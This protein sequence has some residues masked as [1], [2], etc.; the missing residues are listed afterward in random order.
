MTMGVISRLSGVMSSL[1]EGQ[2][3]G[4]YRIVRLLGQGGMGAVYEARQEPLD[5]RVALKTLHADYAK[6][7]DALARF[8]NE[9]KALSKLE[10]PSIVQVS[11]FRNAADGTAYLV[12]E[13]LRGQSLGRRL[14][15][16]SARG[17]RL[18]LIT[19]LQIAFQTAD[20]LAVA[21]KQ[22]IVHRDV[23]PDNLMLIT[24]A[25]APGGERVK[26]L[27][28]GIAKLSGVEDTANVKTATQ[29]VMG[30]PSYMSPEQCAGA[31]GVDAKTD[32]YALGCVLFELLASRPPFVAEGAGQ[33]IGMHLFQTPPMLRSL[34][35]QIPESVAE[36]VHRLLTRE[37][38]Q[39]PTMDEAAD[40]LVRLLP[41]LPGGAAVLR[42]RPVGATDPN[43]SQV[44]VIPSPVSTIGKSMGQKAEQAPRVSLF[45]GAGVA[46]LIT[47]LLFVGWQRNTPGP[48]SATKNTS[49][50]LVVAAPPVKT[51]AGQATQPAKP[52]KP[53]NITWTLDSTPSGSAVI[54]ESGKALGV[55]PLVKSR[56]ASIGQSVLRL[57]HDGYVDQTITLS[58]EKD[59]SQLISLTLISQAASARVPNLTHL[60]TL[61][62]AAATNPTNKPTTAN[63]DTSIDY[64]K[65]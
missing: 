36:L 22:G 50:T 27:D 60:P 18:P 41:R 19:A 45:I 62:K 15:E 59:V 58:N 51:P 17:E 57:H 54:D 23:K 48:E 1:A 33:L 40:A 43:A 38:V 55:T 44:T 63:P 12:M 31:G 32:V 2:R 8:F 65:N 64:E 7:P 16:L 61:K 34:A 56:P 30:T 24:D 39:R 6:D 26:L 3:L 4:P 35:P 29:A 47:G 28:F 46:V 13:F 42:S 25:I 53:R 10:H 21:H 49:Q 5:R 52:E 11:D 37:K 9:A 20:V 14:R